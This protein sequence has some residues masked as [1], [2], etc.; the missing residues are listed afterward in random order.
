RMKQSSNGNKCKLALAAPQTLRILCRLPVS[1]PI[2]M[3]ARDQATVEGSARDVH[4]GTMR[5]WCA[6][7]QQESPGV[8]VAG[9]ER[10]CCAR[11]GAEI[12]PTFDWQ[13]PVAAEPLAIVP[14]RPAQSAVALSLLELAPPVDLEGELE[15]AALDLELQ[16]LERILAAPITEA[17]PA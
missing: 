10:L 13:P 3:S 12:S 5:M 1:G 6:S 15:D 16:R 2:V 11:C 4:P 7:C 9:R 14:D 8:P 17:A